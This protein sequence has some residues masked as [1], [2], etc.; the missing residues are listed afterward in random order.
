MSISSRADNRVNIKKLVYLSIL[1]ACVVV[2]QCISS[3][4]PGF[5]SVNLSLVPIV[6]GAAVCGRFAGGWLG[7][8]CGVIIL[9]D[10]TTSAFLSFNALATILLVLIKGVVSG[11]LGGIVYSLFEKWNKY[12]AVLLS[13]IVVPVINTGIF[14]VGCLL[15]FFDLFAPVAGGSVVNYLIT[16]VIGVNFLFELGVNVVLA[17]TILRLINIKKS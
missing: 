13:A 8:V 1:T 3:F 14:F 16:V 12:V 10:P 9:F 15:F 5:L 2:L 6:I 4:I 7:L 11:F 17:P